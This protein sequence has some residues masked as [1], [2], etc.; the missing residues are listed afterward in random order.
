M[1]PYGTGFLGTIKQ[2]KSKYGDGRLVKSIEDLILASIL[3]NYVR[4]DYIVGNPPYV[5]VLRLGKEKRKYYLENFNA[6]GRINL[7]ILFYERGLQLLDKSGVLGYITPSTFSVYTYGKEL[8]EELLKRKVLEV[9]DLANCESVFQQDVSTAI[10]IIENTRFENDHT[11]KSTVFKNDNLDALYDL[12][13]C[14]DTEFYYTS[15][16]SQKRFLGLPRKIITPLIGD[17]YFSIIEK[18]D[19]GVILDD[20]FVIEQCIRIGSAKWKC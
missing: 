4:Y 5:N 1:A 2:L 15:F 16:V 13:K 19:Q 8:R 10:Y 9:V 7:Y 3:K 18:L 6:S 11:T 20:N 17:K 12:S 14:N